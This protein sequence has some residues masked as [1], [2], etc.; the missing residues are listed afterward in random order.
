MTLIG[1]LV[2]G[3]ICIGPIIVCGVIQWRRDRR[4]A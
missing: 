3:A 1:A 4:K 2:F